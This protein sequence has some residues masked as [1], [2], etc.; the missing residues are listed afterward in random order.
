MPSSPPAFSPLYRWENQG[1]AGDVITQGSAC[2]SGAGFKPRSFLPQCLSTIL[3][4]LV[5]PPSAQSQQEGQTYWSLIFDMLIQ[6]PAS[7]YLNLK[8]YFYI[9]VTDFLM[10]VWNAHM[11]S[12]VQ[13]FATPWTVAWPPGSSVH[14]IFQAKILQWVAISYFRRSSLNQ[15]LNSHLLCLQHWQVG[16]FTTEPAGNPMHFSCAFKPLF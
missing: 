15:E 7:P 10:G 14:G 5:A 1:W 9:Y 12:R 2:E 3:Q 6:K 11:L 8:H 13:L 16:S 4:P